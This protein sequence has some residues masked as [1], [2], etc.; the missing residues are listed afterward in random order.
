MITI[1]IA[2]FNEEENIIP[3]YNELKNFVTKPYEIIW[4]DDGSTDQSLEKIEEISRNNPEVK[5]LS[6]SRNFGHQPALMA[7]LRYATGNTIIIMD[8]DF[9]HPPSMLPVLLD[10]M[11]KG[12]DIVSGKRNETGNKKNSKYFTSKIFYRLI[13]LLSVT[14]IEEASADFRVF[15][16]KVLNTI[17]QFEEKELFL[18]GIFSWIGFRRKTIEYNAPERIHGK[19]K[20]TGKKMISLG[21]KGITSFTFKPLRFS[22]IAGCIF[23]VVSFMLAIAA[24]IAYLYGYTVRGWTSIIIAIMLLGGIQLLF[25]GLIG[26]YIASLLTE[27]K[28]RPIY[29]I[30]KTINID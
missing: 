5:C 10:E 26:E 9:Q 30:D 16:K 14:H 15:N 18:R 24:V 17:L 4:V 12:Y 20:Y 11:S 29:I 8:G 2:I 3:L 27:A 1:I 7:G 21:I 25:L 19:T 13:N 6:F 23:S 22:L 28:K